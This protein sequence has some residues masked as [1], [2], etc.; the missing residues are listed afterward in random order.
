MVLAEAG[1]VVHGI[2]IAAMLMLVAG[3][4]I[5]NDQVPAPTKPAPPVS[6][7]PPPAQPPHVSSCGDD[8]ANS[9][10]A[11][12]NTALEAVVVERIH[13]Q[14]ML[15]EAEIKSE[16]DV[17][18]Q[19]LKARYESALQQEALLKNKIEEVKRGANPDPF[20]RRD[21]RDQPPPAPGSPNRTAFASCTSQHECGR[22]E[23]QS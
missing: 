10:L 14:E 21:Q 13:V 6:T 17:I 8:L 3:N 7:Q 11:A 23:V 16:A 19:S 15:L 2:L 1:A 4:A 12:L 22:L 18:K 5:A 9:D 20:L